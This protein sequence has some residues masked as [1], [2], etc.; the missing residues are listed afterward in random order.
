MRKIASLLSV[1]MLLCTL[2]FAQTRTVTGTIR[3]ANGTAIPFATITESG[4]KN[5]TTADANGAF[6]ITVPQNAR[7]TVSS[8]GFTAATVSPGNGVLALTLERGGDQLNEVV[9][10]ALGIQ[11]QR[12]ELGYATAKVTS[13]DLTKGSP[14]NVANGL[15]GRVSGLNIASVNNG[16]LGEVKMTLRGIRSLTGNNNPMLLLDGV[17]TP[18][19]FLS[20]INPNDITDVTVL[21]GS[22]SAGV[23]GPDARNGVIVVT[24][25]KGGRGGQPVITLSH[26][27]QAD[28]ISFFPKFQTEFGSGGYNEY[29]PY[30]N[31]SWGPAFDGSVKPLGKELEDGT[32]QEVVYSP[33]NDRKKF[34]NTGI[35]NQTDVSFGVKD[36]YLSVQDVR[37]SGI[38]PDDKNRRTG[39]RLNTAREYG[40]FR[41]GFNVNYIQQNYDIFDQTQMEDY[42]IAQNVGQNGGL[43]N[44]IFNTPAQVPITSYKNINDKYSNYNNYFNDY[45]LNPYFAIDNW[46]KTGRNDDILTNLDLNFKA[47]SW[48]NFTYR[49]AAQIRQLSTDAT[50]KGEIPSEWANHERNFL[51][52]ST[53]L[54]ERSNR[55]SRLSSEFFANVNKTFGDFKLN[56]IA[57]HYFR[58][59]DIKDSRVSAANLVVPELFNVASRTGELGGSNSTSR[60]RLLSAYGLVGLSYKGWAN[61]EVTGRNDWTSVLAIGNNSFFYP[62][63]S[64]SLVLTDAI[65]ALKGSP[66]L[67]YLKLRGS[68]NKSGNADIDPYLLAATYAQAGGF[69]YGSLP[70]YTAENTA[71]NP[72]LKPEF[73][74][75]KEIG[76]E[77]SFLKNR[78]NVEAAYYTQSNTDQ[79]IP[80]KVSDATGFSNSY[81]NAAAFT[82]RGV[83]LDLRLTP[84][85]KLGDLNVS[86]TANATYSTSEVNKVYEGLDR[87]FVG[88]YETTAANFAVVGQPAFVFLLTDYVR[89]SLGRVIVNNTTGLPT[90]DANLKQFGRTMPLWTLGLSPTIS[91]KGLDFSVNAE[92]KGGHYVYHNL[93]PEMAWTGVS[94]ATGRN[95][96]EPFVMPNSSILV[97]G[98]YEANTNIPITGVND[99]Y[100]GQYRDTRSNFLTSASAWRIRNVSL[101]YTIPKQILGSQNVVKGITVTL[102][103]RNLFLWVPETN[104]YTDP[105]FNFTAENNSSGVTNAQIYP[106]T[107]TFGANLTVTF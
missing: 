51:S 22:A 20:S 9:V 19:N 73:T 54:A 16:V 63:V 93:G 55:N 24:T 33:T 75:S 1:L 34:F 83:E 78:I 59:Q 86:F 35:T 101:G 42:H 11:R 28:R 103:A 92:Y 91:W 14:V 36:F 32:Q 15:Q 10:T 88:G 89:D 76:F 65:D 5:A 50:S 29:T 67:S 2:A 26:T 69:P 48:L 56:A 99:F 98:K 66:S 4:T 45:G 60:S 70:G 71:Y 17:P 37:I 21:K 25:K 102:N 43:L 8:T 38:T 79:I 23:Y 47:T 81:V 96:R 49:A 44:L 27:T 100:I 57:G 12:K 39:I 18:L 90:K 40:K 61:V 82:N 52:V 6:S 105:D 30:E 3:D 107:R 72:L 64:A 31:W 46:R 53:A 74:E 97:N 106:A 68:W 62:G 84:L 7:L 58:Q 13:A 41:A 95:H 77:A 80:I 85:V 87:I 104:E 94:A